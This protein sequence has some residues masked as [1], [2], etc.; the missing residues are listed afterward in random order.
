M[1]GQTPKKYSISIVI[2]GADILYS[3]HKKASHVKITVLSIINVKLHVH[4]F[5]FGTYMVWCH[6]C[7]LD[8]FLHFMRINNLIK[9]HTITVKMIDLLGHNSLFYSDHPGG[10]L[11]RT[12][13]QGLVC[14][15]Q[16]GTLSTPLLTALSNPF[17]SMTVVRIV[18][19]IQIP[20][21]L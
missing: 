3:K 9:R 7:T 20:N 12:Q 19:L 10:S 17:Q 2:A 18:N 5:V 13:P 4:V 15:F 6:F 14:N 16:N 21:T 1:H 8:Y 11:C